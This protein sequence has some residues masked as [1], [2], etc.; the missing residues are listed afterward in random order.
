MPVAPEN[1]RALAEALLDHS[2]PKVEWTH[3]AHLGATLYLLAARPDLDLDRDMP[4][5]IRSY[6]EA[7][8]TPNTDSGGYHE[9]LTR[10]YLRLLRAVLAETR[11]GAPLEE[12]FA[13]LLASPRAARD[14]PLRYYSKERLFSVSARREWIAPDLASFDF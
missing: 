3:E 13:A 11:P 10:F 14:F 1:L 12:T 5:I 2:L 8:G 7:V 9:T 4:G 6:N